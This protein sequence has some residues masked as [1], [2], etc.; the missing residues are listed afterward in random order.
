MTMALPAA[1][2]AGVP[3]VGTFHHVYRPLTGR[4]R[5]GS[6][7][8]SRSRPAATRRSS[9]PGPRSPRSPTSTGRISRRRRR[10][11]SCTTA[12]TSTTSAPASAG[13]LAAA[14]RRP[15]SRRAAGWSPSLAALRDFKGIGH[16]IRAWPTVAARLPRR[17]AAAG[18]L[19][20]RRRRPCAPRS[21]RWASRTRVVFAGMRTDIPAVLRGSEVVAAA[22]DLRREPADRADGGRRLCAGRWWPATSA[23]SATSSPT[24]RPASWSSREQR[25]AW[26]TRWCGCSDD[27]GLGRPARLRRAGGGW[28]GCSTPGLGREP[29]A[30]YERAIARRRGGRRAA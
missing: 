14:A 27:P 2:L 16:A 11:P 17:P 18:R 10:G 3:A 15:G 1:A 19:A 7:W 6:G 30:L 9:S 21:P 26:P 12:S 25:R 8:P 5:L 4:R 28:S 29:A 13:T 20:G 24:A 23:G 22:V